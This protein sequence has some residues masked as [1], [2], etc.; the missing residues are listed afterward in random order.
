MRRQ[1]LALATVIVLATPVADATAAVRAAQKTTAKKKVVTTKLV[2]AIE[3][4]D[5]WGTVQVTV[6][7]QTTTTS[8][9]KKVTRR[10]TD[11]GGSYTY[12]TGRSQFIMSNALPQLRSEFLSAQSSKVQMVSGASYTSQAFE[13]SLQSALAKAKV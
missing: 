13:E 7:E 1:V 8:G 9:S 5:R 4:A 11:L 3:Q 12:H 10:Y 6:T 2:G